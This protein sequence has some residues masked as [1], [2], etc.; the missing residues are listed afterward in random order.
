M[1]IL[2]KGQW[3]YRSSESISVKPLAESNLIVGRGGVDL[4]K[5]RYTVNILPRNFR[6]SSLHFV[7]TI[8]YWTQSSRSMFN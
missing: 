5:P 6:G 1:D 4:S 8:G 7:C 2:V 3:I